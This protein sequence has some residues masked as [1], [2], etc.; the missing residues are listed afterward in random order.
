MKVTKGFKILK[1]GRGILIILA[2]L[3]LVVFL[4]GFWLRGRHLDEYNKE[5]AAESA[6]TEPLWTP[7]TLPAPGAPAVPAAPAPPDTVTYPTPLP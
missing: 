6:R 5:S 4:V 7:F 1:H 3:I 2:V